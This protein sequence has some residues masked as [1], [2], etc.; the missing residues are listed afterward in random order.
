VHGD[1]LRNGAPWDYDGSAPEFRVLLILPGEIIELGPCASGR[2][3][4]LSTKP[5]H[6]A[7]SAPFR[8]AVDEMDWTLPERIGT[9]WLTWSGGRE[10][11]LH[12]RVGAAELT[13]SVRRAVVPVAPSPP[14]AVDAG[15]VRFDVVPDAAITRRARPR[16]RREGTR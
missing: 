7:T 16:T 14:R 6:L 8:V 5:L 10:E 11:T 4:E 9:A 1:R 2:S 13:V 12:A 3:C 15:V